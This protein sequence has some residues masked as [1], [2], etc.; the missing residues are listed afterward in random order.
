MRKFAVLFFIFFC[1]AAAAY[2]QATPVSRAESDVRRVERRWLDAYEQHD[3]RAMSDIVAD[4][5]V[6]TFPK[7]GQQ[8]KRQILSMISRPKDATN[9][10]NFYTENV[11]A[12]V[13]GETVIMTGRVVSEYMQAGKPVKEVSSYTDTYVRSSGRWQVVASHLSDAPKTPTR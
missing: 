7:D 6:I 1:T 10:S 9:P 2:G 4:D 13:Y 3:T 5:F 12:R 8:T 11:K